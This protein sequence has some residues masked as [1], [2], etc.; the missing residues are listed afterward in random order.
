MQFSPMGTYVVTWEKLTEQLQ[1]NGGNLRIWRADT[2]E[3]LNGFSQ[4]H[5]T[6]DAWPYIMWTD[7]EMLAS[8]AVANGVH[9]YNGQIFAI[10]E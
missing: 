4:K 10:C 5:Y 8:M 6:K 3:F 1:S 7:D 9:L 2:G